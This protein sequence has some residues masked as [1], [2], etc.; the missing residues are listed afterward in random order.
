MNNEVVNDKSLA[1]SVS[2]G[3]YLIIKRIFDIVCSLVGCILLIPIALIV[4]IC[5]ILTGDFHSIIYTHDRIGKNGKIFKL[6]KWI[7]DFMRD[8][9]I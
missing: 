7:S 6:Y 4:K 3:T 8:K 5:Y 2:K 9:S 1:L